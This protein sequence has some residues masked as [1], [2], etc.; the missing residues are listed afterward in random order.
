MDMN[1][2]S[3]LTPTFMMEPVSF[4]L[5]SGKRAS[6]YVAIA[7]VLF[8]AWL[9]QSRK[10]ASKIEVPFYKASKR[11][12]IFDAENLIKDSYRKVG[13]CAQDLWRDS[14]HT[15]P[16]LIVLWQSVPDQGNRG[17]ANNRAVKVRRRTQGASRGCPECHRG[18]S[19]GMSLLP[20]IHDAEMLTMSRRSKPSTPSFHRA[21]MA[22]CCP[23]W[24]AHG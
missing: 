14:S 9:L 22:R 2:S 6:Y 21:I 5:L 18:S 4:S 10:S 19:R 13:R 7:V 15:N 24:S 12:W 23:S 20:G 1:V 3:V 16:P 11:K 8:A 17:S